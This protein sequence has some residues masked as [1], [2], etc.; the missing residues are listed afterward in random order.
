MS[1][2][3]SGGEGPS[4]WSPV[5]SR[6]GKGLEGPA[7][8]VEEGEA[9]PSPPPPPPE[10]PP[11]DHSSPYDA[12]EESRVAAEEIAAKMLFLKKDSRPKSD[13]PE[14]VLQMALLFVNL[15]QVHFFFQTAAQCDHFCFVCLNLSRFLFGC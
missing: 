1:P 5:E 7:M 2:V 8:E 13:L 6:A 12:L 10:Q 15:R 3:Y 4:H 9:V 14:L 11:D